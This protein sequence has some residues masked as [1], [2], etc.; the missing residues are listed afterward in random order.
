VAQLERDAQLLRQSRLQR[1]AERRM[2]EATLRREDAEKEMEA[3]DA[4]AAMVAAM[5]SSGVFLVF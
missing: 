4:A 5:E 1:E 3:R 2:R